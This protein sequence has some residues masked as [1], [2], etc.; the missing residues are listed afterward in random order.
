M[1]PSKIAI[2]D[3]RLEIFSPENFP[4][5]I[6]ADKVDIGVTHIRNTI[7]TRVFRD[8]GI[9][10]KLGSGFITLFESYAKRELP[11]P[12]INEGTGYIKCILP[13]PT[14]KTI[15]TQHSDSS[16]IEQLLIT[17]NTIKAQDVMK[18]LNSS[19]ATATRLLTKLT[20]EGVLEKIGKGPATHYKKL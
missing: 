13:R 17:K 9:I 15:M 8:Y 6:M 18:H 16:R 5:P 1:G 2:Y 19:K 10:E 7:I 20:K 3:D 11:C 4:G 12:V 14:P